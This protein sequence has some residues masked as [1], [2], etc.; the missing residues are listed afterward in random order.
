MTGRGRVD[1]GRWVCHPQLLPVFPEFRPWVALYLAT[2][3]PFTV[4]LAHLA[5]PLESK[6]WRP[7]CS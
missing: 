4:C 2:R 5:S 1:P 7:L 3:A 6:A